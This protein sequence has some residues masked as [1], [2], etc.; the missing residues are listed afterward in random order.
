MMP[1][2]MIIRLLNVKTTSYVWDRFESE[3]GDGGPGCGRQADENGMKVIVV[4]AGITGVSAAEWLRRDGHDVTL[5]DRV[6]PGDPSQA[7]YGNCG[8][9]GRSSVVPVSV[10][11]L[12]WQ[13]PGMLL[14]PDTL[15]SLRWRY[16]PR[17]LPWLAR[18][19][20]NGRRAKVFEIAAAL[21]PL[22]RD[23]DRQH[24]AL[25]AGTPAEPFIARGAYATLYRDRAA[26]E[27]NAFAND[28][29]KRHGITWE[30]WDRPAIEAYD[31]EL[32]DAYTFAIAMRDYLFVTSP[33]RYLATLAEHFQQEG[34]TFVHREVGGIRQMETGKAEVCLVGGERHVADRVV[35]AAGAWSGRF[36]KKLGH[37]TTLESERGYHVMLTGVSHKPPAVLNLPDTGLG[38]SPMERGL[39]FCGAVD[40]GGL[41]GPQNECVFAAI[42]RQVR[43]I[44][45]KLKWQGE[46]TWMGQRPSTVDSLPLLGRS[47]K[48]PSVY[49]A[50]GGQHVGLGIGPRLGRMIADLVSG[51]EADIPLSPYRVDRFD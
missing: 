20:W 34:G 33:P 4:G 40:F 47:P 37:R 46:E 14:D 32:S 21:A 50:F 29:R 48:A 11:G 49:F 31:P 42:R 3:H 2:I 12:L 22:V 44:Y 13:A 39:C 1:G 16:L 5:I 30:E 45:P 28:L 43:R 24:R 23:T 51:R 15:L 10:P 6:P 7:S 38:V 8:I 36:A 9:V 17:L 35:L 18:F 41:D 25:S 19:L 26:F 27:A